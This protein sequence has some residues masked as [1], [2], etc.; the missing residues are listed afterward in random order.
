MAS[1]M[2]T[3]LNFNQRSRAMF[4]PSCYLT[5]VQDTIVKM[6]LGAKTMINLSNVFL[7]S[8]HFIEL[9]SAERDAYDMHELE[10]NAHINTQYTFVFESRVYVYVVRTAETVWGKIFFRPRSRRPLS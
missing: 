5:N 10:K 4:S 6:L 1:K 9:N 8:I 3:S 2:I 7:T